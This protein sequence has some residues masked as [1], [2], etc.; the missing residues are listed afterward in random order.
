MRDIFAR[1]MLARRRALSPRQGYVCAGNRC[2]TVWRERSGNN[3]ANA[4]IQDKYQ[5]ESIHSFLDVRGDDAFPANLERSLQM[6]KSAT[7]LIAAIAPLIAGVSIATSSNAQSATGDEAYCRSLVKAYTHGGTERGFAPESLD[8][9]VAINQC[10]D[11]NP[12]P[13]IPV[14][15]QKLRDS[16]YTLP[17]RS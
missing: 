5:I 14:L 10:Q 16:G 3:N 15:E 11:G 9:S 12:R 13:A 2:E 6:N 4:A 8:T 17:S 1:L 7:L